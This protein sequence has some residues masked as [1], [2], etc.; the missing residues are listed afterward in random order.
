M[1]VIFFGLPAAASTPAKT[2]EYVTKSADAARS[3]VA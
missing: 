2:F 1:P 3:L